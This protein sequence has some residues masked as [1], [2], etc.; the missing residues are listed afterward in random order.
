MRVELQHNRKD[1]KWRSHRRKTRN[2]NITYFPPDVLYFYTNVLRKAEFGSK[3][4][5]AKL[6]I[7]T[8]IISF[9]QVPV[10]DYV[11]FSVKTWQRNLQ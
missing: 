4:L 7:G 1:S 9:P 2:S 10:S 5:R 6:L 8:Q 11:T 3:N